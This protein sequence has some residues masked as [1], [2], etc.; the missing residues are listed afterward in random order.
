MIE[1]ILKYYL[2]RQHFSQIAQ[3]M[4]LHNLYLDH[5]IILNF[6]TEQGNVSVVLCA[7]YQS[8]LTKEINVMEQ[9][10]FAI[11]QLSP[12][13]FSLINYQNVLTTEIVVTVLKNEILQYYDYGLNRSP[14]LHHIAVSGDYPSYSYQQDYDKPQ[15]DGAYTVLCFYPRQDFSQTM[16]HH[17]YFFGT[18]IILKFCTEHGSITA[19]LCAKFQNDF[20]KEINVMKEQILAILPLWPELVSLITSYHSLKGPWSYSYQQDYDKPYSITQHTLQ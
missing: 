18:W 14:L 15:H 2:P 1:H 3:I 6:F 12:E 19:V 16:F 4:F 11:L 10:D 5:Q 7:K 8:D 20:T 17:N 13:P 9:K